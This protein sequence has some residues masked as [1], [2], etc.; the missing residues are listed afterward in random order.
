[1]IPEK[2]MLWWGRFDP[3][4]ARNAIL[5]QRMAALGWT[6]R[7]F[8][9][10]CSPLADVEATLRRI[11]KPDLVWAPCFR[12]RDVA[13][14]RRWCDRQGAP[15]IF[16]P[17]IS[18][19]DK[20]VWERGKLP[21]TSR[22]AQRLLAWERRLF[23]AADRVIADTP[24]H[25]AFF[26]ETLGVAHERLR[27]VLVGA[28]ETR[29]VFAPAPISHEPPELLFFG[30]FIPLHGASTIV[31]AARMD[32][33]ASAAA[34]RPPL[35]WRLLGDGPLRAACQQ[36]AAGLPN[37]AFED[38]IPYS[39]LPARIHRAQILLGV[40]GDTRKAGRVIPNKLYQALAAGRPVITRS[41][42]AYPPAARNSPGLEFV[43]PA[44]PQDLADRAAAWAADRAALALR[45]TA[46]RALYDACFSQT[47][48]QT[49][50]EH[51]LN[52]IVAARPSRG[53]APP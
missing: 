35:R 18:A 1:M 29:F 16:D 52:G 39:D 43:A 10:A 17:L 15:L 42:D 4:Y 19:Y 53:A 30:S 50:L 2:Q 24:C 23:G 5:R 14:A 28:E 22:A 34:G 13:S 11:R 8:Q 46:A 36:A 26:R 27:V 20:Q 41:S 9:P 48:V 47:I 31:E 40:F 7:D 21:E 3:A 32:L 33:A 12:Q 6:I 44:D 38:P 45:G 51:A 25:A 49:Q 37:L